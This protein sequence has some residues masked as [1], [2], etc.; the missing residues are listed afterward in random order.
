M[1]KDLPQEVAWQ[2]TKIG[3]EAPQQEWMKHPVML[4]RVRESRRRLVDAGVLS[5][6]VLDQPLR[7]LPSYAEDNFD[8]RYL[9]A[10]KTLL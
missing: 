6:K 2:I 1:E 4:E 7:A 8:W 9:V 10:A 5:K 3:F